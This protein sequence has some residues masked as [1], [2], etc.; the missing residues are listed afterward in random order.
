MPSISKYDL[1]ELRARISKEF[2]L[3]HGPVI[4]VTQ[5][6]INGFAE[7]TNDNQWPHVD[8]EKAK[9]SHFRTTV[10]HGFLILGL[11]NA[12][13]DPETAIRIHDATKELHVGGSYK[14]IQ[15]LK[16]GWYVSGRERLDAVDL[17]GGRLSLIYAYQIRGG[18][19][20]D[21]D[22]KSIAEGTVQLLYD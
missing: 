8:I 14:L 12:L 20:E 21:G 6:R 11:I 18:K 19:T 15:P 5:R 2:P 4:Q 9:A 17:V 3:K 13:R 22:A 1:P 7:Y 10:A 16:A